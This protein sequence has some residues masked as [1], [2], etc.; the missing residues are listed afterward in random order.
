MCVTCRLLV[1]GWM[2]LYTFIRIVHFVQG[3]QDRGI[4]C[5]LPHLLADLAQRPLVSPQP[6]NRV[7]EACCSSNADCKRC[8]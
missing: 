3:S 8:S 1:C 2:F 5:Q 6:G 4:N 7:K